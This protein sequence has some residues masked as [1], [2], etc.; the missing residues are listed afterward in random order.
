MRIRTQI[1]CSLGIMFLLSCA[2]FAA[3]WTITSGQKQDGLVVNL[4][5]RQR[6]QVQR[7]AKD[8][9]AYAHQAKAGP[10]AAALAEDIRK[11]LAAFESIQA[12]LARGGDYRDGKTTSLAVPDRE[13]AALFEE[14][15]RQFKPFAAEVETILTKGD[16]T[17]ADRLLVASEAVVGAQERAVDKLQAAT[18]ADVATLMAVQATGMGLGAAVFLTVLFLLGRTLNQPLLRLREYAAAVAGGNLKAVAAGGYPPELAELRDAMSRMVASL[19]KEMAEAREKGRACELQTAETQAALAAARDQESRTKDLL[20]RMNEAAGKARSVSQSVMDESSNLLAQAEQV[21][22]GAQHQRD[23][24]IETATAMEEM[25][26]TVLEV[27]R[28]AAAAAASAD[29]AKGKALTGAEGVRS[30]VSSIETIRTRILDLKESMTR[31]GQQADNIGHIMN[32]ISDIA[33]QTNLLALNAAIEAARAGDAGR[34]FAV[35]ADE[36]RKLAEKTMAATKEVG[37]AVVSIQG[38]AREN[39]AAVESAASGIEESTRAAADSGRFMDEIVGIVDVTASQVESIA[40]ASEEQSATS[41]EINR[42]VEEVNRIANETADGMEVATAALAALS[43]L[44]GELDEVIRQMTG[45][46]TATRRVV[47][48]PPRAVAASRAPARAALPPSRPGA[49]PQ[50]ASRPVPAR[51][52]SASRP[53]AKALP[54]ARPAP[55]R[56]A[57]PRPTPAKT[58]AA[59]GKPALA[60]APSPAAKASGNGGAAACSIG[61]GILQWDQSLAVGI[62]EID[63]QHQKLVGMICDLHEA[64][65]SGKGKDQV[66]AILRE[67]ENYAVEHFGYEEKLMEQYKYPAYRNHRKEHEAFVDK[68][69]AFGNDFRNNRAALTTEV[70]NFLKNWLVGHIKGTDQKYSAFFNERGVN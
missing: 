69:I 67:L 23:R 11:R 29:G 68:V 40:T 47:P 43:A 38:Q 1:L 41:E 64:M 57:A 26:S 33:D 60:K 15:S 24:M 58:P 70:M 17:T 44:S 51:S 9:L 39:I 19:E 20:A 35:V 22:S 65:R 2:M 48:T 18:E 62:G 63:G 37:D 21:A 3:T 6:M 34:G 12:L 56:P 46:T 61:G 45:D 54:A 32:V 25:N 27:A 49:K 8:V 50:V 28:N 10:A 16:G 59:F 14:A 5:G 52:L 4:A 31:L 42:A 66:E 13:T 36:V 7:I 30:A 53:A 55:A